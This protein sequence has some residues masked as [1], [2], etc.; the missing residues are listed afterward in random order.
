MHS[1]G[2]VV[3]MIPRERSRDFR[4]EEDKEHA[5]MER[6]MQNYRLQ[7]VIERFINVSCEPFQETV[8]STSRRGSIPLNLRFLLEVILHRVGKQ[9]LSPQPTNALPHTSDRAPV[10]LINN[11]D[12]AQSRNE[13]QYISTWNTL[14]PTPLLAHFPQTVDAKSY[15]IQ[16][17]AMSS[18]PIDE[19]PHA[20]EGA[21]EDPAR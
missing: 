14:P 6:A 13:H 11:V 12:N 1:D 2:V 15:A 5:C 10:L 7:R 20:A 8:P 3:W 18:S 4:A 21:P 16:E 19:A 17:M 9:F